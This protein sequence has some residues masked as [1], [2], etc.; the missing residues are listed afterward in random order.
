MHIFT[1]FRYNLHFETQL[2]FLTFIY[3]KLAF[4]HCPIGIH[5]IIWQ[6]MFFFKCNTAS[7]AHL[8]DWKLFSFQALCGS[9]RI[10]YN[11]TSFY[12]L[13]HC[14]GILTFIRIFSLLLN[15]LFNWMQVLQFLFNTIFNIS[16]SRVK[17]FEVVWKLE[18]FKSRCTGFN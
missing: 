10:A 8:L 4:L 7:H 5:I 1:C 3:L 18:A 2:F 6:F 17:P 14:V 16:I 12:S 15:L 9:V 11:C 13:V